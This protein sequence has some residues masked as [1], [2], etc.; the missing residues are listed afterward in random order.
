MALSSVAMATTPGRYEPLEGDLIFQV[1]GAG[2]MSQAIAKATMR[3]GDTLS[4]DHVGIVAIGADNR[5][6]V[7]E[8]S[9]SEGVT[10]TP[11]D[12]FMSSPAGVVAMRITVEFP[13]R[14]S[15]ARVRSLV[16]RPYDWHF[17]A[18]N[19][20]LYCS[21]LVQECFL[22]EDGA[23]LF[24]PIPLTFKDASGVT[25]PYWADLYEKLDEPIPEGEPGSSPA[26]LARSPLLREVYTA[27]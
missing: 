3:Q 7:I 21:E 27:R 18:G 17:R 9:P 13:V 20:S 11:I 2:G 23:P 10:V 5:P 24:A 26:S 1:S 8:A 19:D 25:V 4:Y 22:S 12:S 15:M 14:E 16:G 6:V